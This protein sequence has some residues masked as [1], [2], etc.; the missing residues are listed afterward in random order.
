[1]CLKQN[2]SLTFREDAF[3]TVNLAG[4]LFH[5]EDGSKPVVV[6]VE[7]SGNPTV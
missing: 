5:S 6:G 7:F 3:D 4:S 2:I 1:M